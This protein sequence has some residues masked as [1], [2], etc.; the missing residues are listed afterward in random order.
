MKGKN[1][2][3]LDKEIDKWGWEN[4]VWGTSEQWKKKFFS[5][6]NFSSTRLYDFDFPP[7]LPVQF[8]FHIFSMVLPFPFLSFPFLYPSYFFFKKEG[9]GRLGGEIGVILTS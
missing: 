9:R 1:C 6:Y 5:R 7:N 8:S 2:L 3:I 4:K